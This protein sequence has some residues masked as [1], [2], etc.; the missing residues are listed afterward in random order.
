VTSQNL[1]YRWKS[2]KS[3]VATF[4]RSVDEHELHIWFGGAGAGRGPLT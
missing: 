1:I 2:G 3:S 4:G